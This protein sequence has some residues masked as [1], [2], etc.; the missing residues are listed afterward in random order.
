VAI[1]DTPEQ[2]IEQL[3]FFVEHLPDGLS[4]DIA[5]LAGVLKE[6]DEAEEQGIGFTEKPMPEPA[7]VVE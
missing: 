5:P 1:G 4:A 2:V 7:A 6:I 3:K